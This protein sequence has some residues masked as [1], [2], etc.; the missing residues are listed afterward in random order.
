MV[1][2][3]PLRLNSVM[4]SELSK[5]RELKLAGGVKPQSVDRY[6]SY[7]DDFYISQ[8][9][10][11]IT[12]TKEMFSL[13]LM[14]RNDREGNYVRY[15]RTNYLIEFLSFLYSQNYEVYI[16]R[17][18]PC[19]SNQ[20][21]AKIFSDEELNRY[22]E[23]VDLYES[24]RDP[25]IALYTPVIFR[26]LI[27][28][29]TRVGETLSL[30]VEDVDL[31]EGLLHL[32][33]TKNAKFRSIPVSNSLLNVLRQYADRCLYLKNKKDFF[34]SHIDG[35]KVSEQSIYKVHR[36]ALGYAGIPYIGSTN[37]P[38]LHDLR[39]T[40]AVNSLKQF[41]HKG[42]D[43]NNVLPILQKYLGHSSISSTEK[44]LQL[45]SE[46]FDDVLDK[47]K[48]TESIVMGDKNYE[49]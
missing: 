28:C 40:F 14:N 11:N 19:K 7:I 32:K 17:R 27:G 10:D 12:F 47:S 9:I 31:K 23:F 3:M 13:W 18:L 29:G 35:R 8:K 16:P 39:H 43:L 33:E 42:C 1:I 41:E 25:M 15:T 24:S 2:T 36:K 5:F 44:Y 46:N 37:G 48:H 4:N 20:F 26:V 21:I 38:R 30:K 49:E 45:I 22:L 6:I 34:F